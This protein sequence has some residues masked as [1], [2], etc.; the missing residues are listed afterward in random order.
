MDIEVIT[1]DQIDSSSYW[2][3]QISRLSYDFG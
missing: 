3:D 1:Q 2:I